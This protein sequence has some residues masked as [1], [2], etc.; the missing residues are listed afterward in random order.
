MSRRRNA[1][2][3]DVSNIVDNY[4]VSDSDLSL[5]D[6]SEDDF[7]PQDILAQMSD[8]SDDDLP[9]TSQSTGWTTAD[10]QPPVNVFLGT[11]GPTSATRVNNL[12]SPLDYFLLIFTDDVLGKVVLETNRYAAQTMAANPPTP[13]AIS[14]RKPWTDVNEEELKKFFGLIMMMGFVQKNG[15]LSSYWSRDWRLA[16]PCFPSVMTRNRFQQI[17]TYLHF[18]NNAELHENAEDKLY[19]IRPVYSLIV[20]R[21]RSLYNLGEAISIDEGMMKW[22]G[23]LSFRVY[24]KDKPTK[25]GVKSYI[26]A[27]AKTKYCWNIDIYHGTSKTLKETVTAL[28]TPVC[29]S[30]WYSLYMD[31]FYNSLALSESLLDKKDHTVRTLR[32]HRGEPLESREPGMMRSGDVTARDNGKVMVLAWKDRRGKG[33]INQRCGVGVGRVLILRSQSLR[34]F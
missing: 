14:K 4:L 18:N 33:H 24:Q 10:R 21:W 34:I 6:E 13:Y 20:E 27:D 3:L 26:L 11:Q 31:N 15:R 12:E 8:D 25:Y 17:S 1:S 23:R 22:R 30:M 28:L 2:R 16:T 29:T 19:K 32:K 5:L 7:G 9:R